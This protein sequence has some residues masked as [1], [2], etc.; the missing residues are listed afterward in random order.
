MAL[1]PELTLMDYGLMIDQDEAA[2]GSSIFDDYRR[3][4]ENLNTIN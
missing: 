4:V 3:G 2:K 1:L